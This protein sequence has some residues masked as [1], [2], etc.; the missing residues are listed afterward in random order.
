MIFMMISAVICL[1][2]AAVM[3]TP[4]LRSF[5]FYRQI[6]LILLFEGIWQIGDFIFRQIFPDNVFMQMIHYIGFSLLGIYFII[7]V[8]VTKKQGAS[9]K[10]QIKK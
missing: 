10:K 9:R 1:A 7:S 3:Y 4:R 6:G 5:Q 2:C 8:I